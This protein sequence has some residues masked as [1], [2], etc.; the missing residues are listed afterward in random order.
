MRF[1]RTGANQLLVLKTHYDAKSQTADPTVRPTPTTA[2]GPTNSAS[3]MPTASS[4]H[5]PAVR[6]IFTPRPRRCRVGHKARIDLAVSDQPYVCV[7]LSSRRTTQTLQATQGR[8]QNHTPS[9]C[10]LDTRTPTPLRSAGGTAAAH[11]VPRAVATVA[12]KRLLPLTRLLARQDER[13][14]GRC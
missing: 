8:C 14:L 9:M 7:L 3:T 1:K 6:S 2:G 12:G 13:A 4:P 5:I 10:R 11:T